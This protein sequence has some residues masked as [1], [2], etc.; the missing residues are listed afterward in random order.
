GILR[1][2]GWGC[3]GIAP[4]G[5][6]FANVVL[7]IED[8]FADRLH[9]N[10]AGCFDRLAAECAYLRGATRISDAKATGPFDVPTRAV[11]TAG[12]L[13]VGD[14]AGYFDPLT[15]QGIHRA[16]LGARLAASVADEC[17]RSDRL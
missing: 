8:R 14:A 11:A 12:V 9:G 6:G 5:G 15:G 16:L 13:L 1:M 2:T 17:L 10:P 3:V 4:L 7:V